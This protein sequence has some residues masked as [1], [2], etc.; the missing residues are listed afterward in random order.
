MYILFDT[1]TIILLA[2]LLFF[3]VIQLVYYWGFLARPYYYL[4]KIRKNKIIFPNLQ[5]PV[6]VII[7]ARNEATGLQAFLPSVLE[8]D[9]PE[10]E[11]IVVNDDSSDNSENILKRLQA[12]YPH[13]Y[14]TYIPQ[15]TKNL[16][17]KKLGLTLGIKAAKHA[18]LLFTEADSRPVS[19]NW[20]NCM[21]RH[22]NG[23]KTI[24][25]GFSA[26]ERRNAL[27]HKYAAFD[28]FFVNLQMAAMALLKIPYGANGRNLVYRK[29]YFDSQKGYSRRR[30]LPVGEDDLF[31][32]EIATK[33]NL[34][35]ELSP[36]S[37]VFAQW[38]EMFDWKCAKISRVTTQHFY[39]KLP[40]FLWRIELWSRLFF[41]AAFFVCLFY[42]IRNIILP[43]SAILALSG[44][45]FSQL[46][47]INK[48][49]AYLKLEKFY[50]L[51]PFFD[52]MQPI[53]NIY[54]YIYRLFERKTNYVWKYEK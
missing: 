38:D 3:L 4:Q 35:V 1:T 48:T 13:L 18:T 29:E 19:S 47:V 53:V 24:V 37:L 6:S 43:L 26:L 22:L 8:Q 31:V 45:L 17:R 16:C 21:S 44:R 10:Y 30:H 14:Y 27:K 9:Y 28:Y 34:A 49:A 12:Q 11:V 46:F 40:V 20:I 36:E 23:E 25:L 42:N 50:F 32:N 15:G 5:P 33:E 7:Y 41:T 51:F 39:K 2:T 52:I 54:F